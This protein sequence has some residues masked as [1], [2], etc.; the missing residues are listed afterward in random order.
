MNSERQLV[1]D[2][3]KNKCKIKQPKIRDSVRRNLS[4]REQWNVELHATVLTEKKLV[5]IAAHPERLKEVIFIAERNP[6]KIY[7]YP[8]S[9]KQKK[10]PR[11]A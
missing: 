4:R 6:R 11:K 3:L 9:L 10:N 1:D 2:Y 8:L 7:R 5:I